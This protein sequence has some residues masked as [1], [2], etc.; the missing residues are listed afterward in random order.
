MKPP[1]KIPTLAEINQSPLNG[2]TVASTFAGGGGSSTGWR[3]AGFKVVW[4]N[5]FMPHAQNVYKAN[6][7]STILD[8]RD[9]R[10]VTADEILSATGLAIGELDVLDGSP[11]CQGFSI[12]N[13]NRM[14]NKAK[15]YDNGE[16]QVNEQMFF[17]YVRL[18][19][20]LKP[21]AFVAENVKGLTFG[22]AKSVMGDFQTDMFQ[23][24]ENTI[25]HALMDSGYVVCW[26]ILNA[27]DYGTPQSRPR[28]FFI[29][30]RK[31]LGMGP[32]FPVKLGYQYAVIDALPHL[33]GFNLEARAGGMT[34]WETIDKEKPSP[35]IMA[36]MGRANPWKVVI[37][38][39]VVQGEEKRKFTIDELK[40]LGGFPDDYD[41]T[42]A[43]SY[44]RQWEIIGNSVCPPQM[45]AIAECL[46][47]RIFNHAPR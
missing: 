11:P 15:T 36:A 47:T 44:G 4:A 35:V 38:V 22:K 34:G 12:A 3:W 1:Y 30:V 37:G 43:G 28:V 23:S 33:D 14:Q 7:A 13:Q 16:T 20:G 19:R 40:R 2:L 18:L 45:K 41:L 27:E 29:G 5:E 8:P 42:P 21:R 39:S 10:K 32:V 6:H 46:A 26:Q 25:L 31:D 17:E 24:Q 9:I